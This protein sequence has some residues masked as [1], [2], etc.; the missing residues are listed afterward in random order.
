MTEKW[1]LVEI[2]I[3]SYIKD[4]I[5][6]FLIELG[7]SGI[8]ETQ[9]TIKGYFLEEKWTISKKRKL[10]NYLKNLK[11]L[12][13]ETKIN[14]IRIEK[15]NQVNWLD[16][17]KKYYKP[18]V[19]SDKITVFP[20]WLSVPDRNCVIIYPGAAFGTGTHETTRLVLKLLEKYIKKGDSVLDFGTGSGILAIASI[21][22]GAKKVIAVDNN[23]DAIL[24]AEKNICLNGL[25]E[26]VYLIYG[27]ITGLRKE[28]FDLVLSNIDFNTLLNYKKYI[29]MAVRKDG[30]II[31]SGILNI[32][33]EK[34]NSQFESGKLKLYDIKI[35]G[36][37]LGLVYRRI[38]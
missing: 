30:Y 22:L 28:N 7:S 15:Q 29:E 2:E 6:N 14:I 8:E 26:R 36:E 16:E 20:P 25:T 31:V 5:S 10:F 9:T 11:E 19:V 17:W 32:D 35:D 12:E 1:I 24:N 37:W 3:N 33:E 38:I 13:P 23:K 4:P 34:F 27:S 21:K 18:V